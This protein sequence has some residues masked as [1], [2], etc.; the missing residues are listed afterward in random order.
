[1]QA[2]AE[3]SRL[4]GQSGRQEQSSVMPL[5]VVRRQSRITLPKKR[6]NKTLEIRAGAEGGEERHQVVRAAE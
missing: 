3:R 6:G 2:E 5:S 4:G 1:M